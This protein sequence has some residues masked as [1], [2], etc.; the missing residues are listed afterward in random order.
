MASAVSWLTKRDDRLPCGA[1]S[2]Y[3]RIVSQFS[4]RDDHLHTGSSFS[5]IKGTAS[6]FGTNFPG[7]NG[8]DH[9]QRTRTRLGPLIVEGRIEHFGCDRGARV[10]G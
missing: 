1:P 8:E 9:S 5:S 4:A 6:D 3:D 10:I 2:R 7:S